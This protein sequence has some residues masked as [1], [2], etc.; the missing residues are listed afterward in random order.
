MGVACVMVD[1]T[2]WSSWCGARGDGLWARTEARELAQGRRVTER[3]SR[4]ELLQPGQRE[5]P[6]GKVC[7]EGGR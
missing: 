3:S 6:R 4:Q 1:E 2:E 5:G 7:M